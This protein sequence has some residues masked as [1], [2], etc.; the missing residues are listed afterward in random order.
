MVDKLVLGKDE[1]PH[2]ISL[3]PDGRRIVISGGDKAMEARLLIA[4]IDSK[5]G[6][7][8]L[9]A[10]FRPKGA[11]LPGIDF[12]RATWPHGDSGK[13]IPHGAVFSR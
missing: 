12:D 9:D 6:K 1:Q 3:A 8:A 5:S 7:L 11:A 2:W 4:T 13:A 10:T